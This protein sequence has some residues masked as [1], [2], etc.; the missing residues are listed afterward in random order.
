M[1]ENGS[2]P[3]II[4]TAGWGY[5]W[6]NG[7]VSDGVLFEIPYRIYLHTGNPIPLIESADFFRRYLAYLDTKRNENGFVSFGLPDWACPGLK[8]VEVPS[9]LINAVFEYR[10]YE[11]MDLTEQLASKALTGTYRH[12]AETLKT[13]IMNTYFIVSYNYPIHLYTSRISFVLL[14]RI[15]CNY[16]LSY[17]TFQSKLIYERSPL[18]L[19]GCPLGLPVFMR[20]AELSLCPLN[21]SYLSPFVSFIS[22]MS[23]A[24]VSTSF[25]TSSAIIS[26]VFPLS[27]FLCTCKIR[28]ERSP[29]ALPSA[30]PS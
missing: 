13:L 19:L 8:P 10:F 24:I 26:N 4:P 21:L 14:L 11:I 17:S 23:T 7:P 30:T 9:E 15:I 3:G 5:E 2:L 18:N 12:K 28:S 22:S 27:N 29:S 6:G 1:K 16:S 20:K 25:S